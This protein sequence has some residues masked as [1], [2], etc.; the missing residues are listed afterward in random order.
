[1]FQ[2]FEFLHPQ[3]LWLL[4]L[5][6]MLT[7]W[8]YIVDKKDSATLTMASTK[9]FEMKPSIW[10]KLKPLLNVLRLFA[11]GLLIIALARPRNV[12]VSKRIN[13]QGN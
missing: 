2:N 5:V 1:M 4:I 3:F 10:S 7:I 13:K 6:P 12:S 11:I 9:G 8:Y